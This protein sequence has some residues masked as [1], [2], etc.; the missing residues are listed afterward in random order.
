MKNIT[1]RIIGFVLCLVM[2][3]SV[4]VPAFAADNTL[5]YSTKYYLNTSDAQNADIVLDMIDG[6][7]AEANIY[8]TIDLGVTTIA[9]DLRSVNG[10]C[11]TI[12]MIKSV[13]GIVAPVVG[14]LGDLNF[15]VWKS[16]M[17]RGSQ[18]ITILNEVLE[19][20]GTTEKKFLAK[21]T[22]PQVLASLL[23]GSMDLGVLGNFVNMEDISGKDGFYGTLKAGIIGTLYEEGTAEYN[24]AYVKPL[25]LFLSEDIIGKG[26]AAPDGDLPGFVMNSDS[27]VDS[28]LCSFLSATWTKY[29]IP[30][31]K[32]V[33]DS[34]VKDENGNVKEELRDLAAVMNLDGAS[35][36]EKSV[37]VD[38]TKSFTSQINN[39]LG[40]VAL[41]FFPGA[42]WTE[43]D[44]TKISQNISDLY[45]Y[46]IGALRITSGS[47]SDEKALAVTKYILTRIEADGLNDYIKGL[48]NVKTMEDAACVVLRNTAKISGLTVTDKADATYENILGDFLVDALKEYIPFSYDAGAGKNVYEV[49][50]DALNVIMIDKGFAKAL[51][52]SMEKTDNVFTKLD[53]VFAATKIFEGLTPAENYKT[54]GY[55]KDLISAVFTLDLGK[56]LDL[57]AVRFLGDFGSRKAVEVVYNFLYNTLASFFAK[58]IIVPFTST[59]PLDNLISN[60]SL[61]TTVYNLLT[62]LNS[63]KSLLLSPVLFIG[64]VALNDKKAEL[65]AVA[66]QV[67]EG[68]EVT[69]SLDITVEGKK[70]QKDV[71]YTVEYA[72]NNALGTATATVKGKGNYT[73]S[74]SVSF[75]IGLNKVKNLKATTGTN[76]VKLTWSAVPGAKKYQIMNG[77]SLVATTSKLAYGITKLSPGKTYKYSVRAV[78]DNFVSEPVEI[79]AVTT[80]DQVKNLKASTV[81]ADSIKVTWSKVAGAKSYIVAYNNGSKWIKKTVTTNSFTATKLS[82]LKTYSFKV[83]AKADSTGKYSTAIKVTTLPPA[84]KGIKVTSASESAINLAWTKVTGATSY[85]VAYS[86]D[87]KKWTKKTVTS[88]KFTLKS[89]KANK[90]YQFKIRAYSKNTKKYGAYSSVFKTSTAPL[91]VTGLKASSIT[92]NSVKLSWKAATGATSYIIAY[93][94]DKKTWKTVTTKKT[95]YVLSSLASNKKYY[96]KVCAVKGA[97]KS[98][99]SSVITAT[100]NIG[101]PS[102]LKASATK[103]S[104]KLTWKAVSGAQGYEIYRLEGKT[105][106]KIGTVKKGSTVS[107]TDKGLKRNTSYSYKIRAYK[108]VSKKNVYSPYSS[109]LTA[110]TKIF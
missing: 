27:T 17:K 23:S 52:I 77:T 5:T 101:A 42:S 76:Y 34:W 15:S 83:C 82:G 36:D 103:N 50:N 94:T 59:N 64:A 104:L 9:I 96:F 47:S 92:S 56:V 88:P 26:I 93:S 37:A 87:G 45:D 80:L 39:I 40:K 3:V 62:A 61:K 70:L 53:K 21:K 71:D 8:E 38:S 22:N 57:T 85:E 68:K 19:L 41:F 84:V 2:I 86:A 24:A 43:G 60:A 7:L 106:K 13:W 48:E 51:N 44:Y 81:K 67:Y 91:K 1:K 28:I 29:L 20:L 31:I 75:N 65:S 69:P 33:N 72:D 10:V 55:L 30:L 98:S 4:A 108:V 25:D 35:F 107:F 18:D 11:D 66:D 110:K 102:G 54:E 109:V 99:F 105:Y 32:G 63:R 74:A 12:D 97:A 73:G 100:T 58:E 95:A 78:C 90:T 16:D 49:L 14:D 89:L 79:S 6:A 46:L